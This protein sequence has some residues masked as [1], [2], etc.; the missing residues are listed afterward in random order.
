[1]ISFGIIIRCL[2]S[3]GIISKNYQLAYNPIAA[4]FLYAVFYPFISSAIL[5]ATKTPLAEAWEREC[6]MPEPS[7]MI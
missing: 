1:M 3:I 5:R 6:V 2:L 7:P 4:T